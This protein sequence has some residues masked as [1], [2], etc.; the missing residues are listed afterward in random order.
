MNHFDFTVETPQEWKEKLYAKTNR[1]GT[2][3]I[4]PAV[5]FA[6]VLCV[7]VVISGTAVA[8]R[9]VN[10]PEYFGSRYLG[11]T[12]EAGEIYS[13]KN[14][15]FESSRDDLQLTCVGIIGDR[16]GLQMVFHLTSTGDM[17]FD[18][19]YIYHFETT[20]QELGFFPEMAKSMGCAVIDERTLRIEFDLYGVSG[21]NFVGKKAEFYFENLE[22]YKSGGN[23]S[24]M[25]VIPC[26]FEG[27]FTVD[28]ADTTYKLGVMNN[29]LTVDGIR[30]IP[31]KAEISNM[32]LCYEM[33]VTQG[34]DAAGTEDDF[35]HLVK[36]TLTL[37]LSDGSV[38]TYDLKHPPEDDDDV[39][40]S[41]VSRSGDR[42][43]FVLYFPKLIRSADVVKVSVDGIDLFVK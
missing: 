42:L 10:A 12:P 34:L 28:Y 13:E 29:E 38:K 24:D 26:A 35:V 27:S 41:S 33:Q 11:N 21:G 22:K 25:Q 37:E 7:L 19:S 20:S 9:V 32:H 14:V 2:Y 8:G 39:F 6:A 40:A 4:K 5:L 1:T 30:M 23:F 3:R 17:R 36:G 43:S 16:I 18:P 15:V 31:K